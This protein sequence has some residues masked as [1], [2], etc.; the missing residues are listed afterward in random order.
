MWYLTLPQP[1]NTDGQHQHI[2]GRVGGP[3]ST[4]HGRE[5]LIEAGHPVT[6][7]ESNTSDGAPTSDHGAINWR[8]ID[9]DMRLRTSICIQSNL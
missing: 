1:T 6:E 3:R 7:S 8:D 9:S 2:G 4:P 5:H